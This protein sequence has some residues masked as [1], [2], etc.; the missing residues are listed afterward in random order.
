MKILLVSPRVPD[1]FWSF[2]HAL[3]FVSKKAGEPPLGLLTVAAMLPAEWQKTLVDLNV[4]TL[5][6]S[7]IAEA[8]YVFLSAMSVQEASA[9]TV[10]ERC[11]RLGT[12]VV[13][14]GPLFT[15]RYDEFEGVDHFVLNEAEITLPLFL[16]D[17]AHSR[18]QHRLHHNAVG[19]PHN[20]TGAS[21]GTHRLP[22]LRKHEYSVL[23]GL[24]IRLR[25]LRYHRSLRA[26][27]TDKSP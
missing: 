23:A 26:H 21:L 5:N 14:G 19:R 17:L 7:E 9:R 6:D 1:T 12:K 13:A 16:E 18:A 2:R 8:D 25:I 3:K 10:I 15:A 27:T 24:S 11:G 20:D 4:R 22:P